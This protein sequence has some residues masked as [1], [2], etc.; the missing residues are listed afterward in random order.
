MILEDS[1]NNGGCPVAIT[2]FHYLTQVEILD[3][4]MVVSIAKGAPDRGEI[5]LPHRRTHTVHVVQIS[6]Y[7]L[8]GTFDQENRVI[9]LSS[10]K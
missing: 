10:I 3:R 2:V 8:D 7:R 4:E 5:G 1:I 9:G 6:P